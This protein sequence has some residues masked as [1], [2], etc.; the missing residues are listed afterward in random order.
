MLRDIIINVGRTG[1]IKPEAVLEPVEIGGVTV[2]QATLHNEDYILSRDIRIGDTVVVK[3]AGD[4]I[5]QVVKPIPEARTGDERTWQMPKTC[6][7]CGNPLE[8]LEGEADYYCVASDCPAQF[9]RLVEHYAG[10]GAMDIEGLGSKLPVVLVEAGLIKTLADLYRLTLEDLLSLEG[11]AEKRAQ[12]LLDAL[13]DSK[14]RTLSR[15]LFGLGLRHVGKT[16]AEL[17]VAHHASLADLAAADKE[18]LEAI[19]GVGPRIAQSVVDWFVVED[20]RRLVDDLRE[21]G[22]NTERLAE[23]AP[24]EREPKSEVMGKTF[25]LTGTL[26]DMGRSEAKA[27]IKKAGGKVTGSVSSKTDYLVAGESPGSKY[28]K[29]QALG[30]EILDEAGLMRL[31]G[32]A[33]VG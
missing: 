24:P 22:V 26:P 16:V 20:N 5:P 13:E 21:L 23:E 11:F 32:G 10:R 9:I 28:D 27:L 15:L 33:D 17:I 12:N 30:I 8:R 31:L 2:S 14:R 7:A 6:P 3:R 1:V 29:A 25:V 19:D 18:S 4:V